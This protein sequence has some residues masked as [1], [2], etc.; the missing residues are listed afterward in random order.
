MRAS[1]AAKLATTA[2][3][4]LASVAALLLAA[5]ML[6]AGIVAGRPAPDAPMVGAAVLGALATLELATAYLMFGQYRLTKAPAMTALGGGY[7]FLGGCS[8]LRILFL[9]RATLDP[10]AITP[11]DWLHLIGAA[12]FALAV[13]LYCALHR[14]EQEEADAIA[15]HRAP[16]RVGAGA[17]AAAAA[18]AVTLDLAVPSFSADRPWLELWR[19]GATP[20]V[21]ALQAMALAASLALGR[22]RDLIQLWLA[23]AMLASVGDLAT[24]TLGGTRASIGGY[25]GAG[26]AGVAAGAVL[27]M[28]LREMIWLSLHIVELN[29]RL[30]RQAT[31]DGLTGVA[32]RRS[33]EDHLASEWR[34]AQRDG[35]SIAALMIDIDFFKSY[36]DHYG[37]IAGDDCIRKVA[38]TLASFAKR[39]GDVAARYG[40][41]EFALILPRA[42]AAAAAEIA[43]SLRAAVAAL[44]MPHEA[45]AVAPMV[46]VSV[47]W[48]AMAPGPTQ[49]QR[50]LIAA[51][52]A[53]LYQA[54]RQ[55]R[56]QAAGTL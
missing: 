27:L 17:L 34:R 40:G 49:D 28:L 39:A 19:W 50:A 54:K 30:T 53:A 18:V 2:Q 6:A 29:A 11:Q 12:G 23:V 45:S 47:G 4:R 46:T 5:G 26:F 8:A 55:G 9:D 22:G 35:V 51:A 42:D 3:L 41:E 10:T 20:A 43:E 1:V 56:N 33:F 37:H 25:L 24:T 38:A 31:V 44:G 48:A 21:I 36:N 52:D 13:L 15:A 7:A 32:N 14:T 16:R